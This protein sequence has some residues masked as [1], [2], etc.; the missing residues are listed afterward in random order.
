MDNSGHGTW[1][2]SAA[3]SLMGVDK[4]TPD[5]R[6]GISCFVRDSD[7]ELTGWAKEFAAS[8]YYGDL[9]LSFKDEL[10]KGW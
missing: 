10:K 6:S 8:P 9:L 7:G 5:L 2:N 4:D 1:F 3:L